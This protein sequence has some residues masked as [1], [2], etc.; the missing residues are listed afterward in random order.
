[1]N[2]RATTIQPHQIALV[3]G[4][5][6][7]IGSHLAEALARQGFEVI[8]VDDLSTG[9][10]GNIPA[11]VRLIEIDIA[12]PSVSEL[13][14]DLRPQL[15]VHAAAQIHVPA[16]VRDP[17]RDRDVNLV[18]TENVI[19]GARAAR[20]RKLVF[21][22]SGGA[23]YGA[24]SGA[25]EETL[26]APESPYGVHKLAAESYVRMSGIPH[27]IVRFSNVY[28]PRQR[29]DLEGGVVSIFLD[30]CVAGRPVAIYGDGRQT[31]DFLYIEDAVSGTLAVA[32]TTRSGTWNVAT[33]CATSILELLAQVERL[34]GRKV[35]VVHEAPR[36]GDVRSSTLIVDRIRR[37]LAWGPT[38]T[39][40]SG[41][42]AMLSA[43]MEA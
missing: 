25:T 40:D 13:I 8:V 1:M 9:S 32:R 37:E 33:G 34:V 5:A 23:I 15:I 7:F 22:S 30:A 11:G 16:S 35:T 38:A 41:L 20:V 42:R 39:L 4:G 2:P 27:G 28:G 19:R 12:S 18:G 21:L 17:A 14:I 29:R 31:R 26:P 10:T 36:V 24:T 6:G 3:T 43:A